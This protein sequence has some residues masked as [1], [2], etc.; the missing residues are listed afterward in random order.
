M[1]TYGAAGMGRTA[2]AVCG[3]GFGEF[4]TEGTCHFFRRAWRG[5]TCIPGRSGRR[6]LIEAA[7]DELAA[8]LAAD[9]E[10]V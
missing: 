2:I 5:R 3:E 10:C 4:W 6:G 7:F 1:E 9:P 8:T